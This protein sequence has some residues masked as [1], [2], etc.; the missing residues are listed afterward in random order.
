MLTLMLNPCFKPLR[1]VESF[2]GHGNAIHLVTEYDEN[3]V[4][5]LIMIVFD[6][7]NPITET[8]IPPIDEHNVQ[9]E[10]EDNMFS[11]GASIKESSRAFVII[12][13]FLFQKLSIPQS[14]YKSFYLVVDPQGSIFECCFLT[15]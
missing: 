7:L 11:V 6:R 13:L 3:E 4:T 10:E 2:V 1:V 12:E 8:I 14:M 15:K 5:P 9:I